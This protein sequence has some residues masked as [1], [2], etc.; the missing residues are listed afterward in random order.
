MEPLPPLPLQG[1][2]KTA[3][4]Q[5]RVLVPVASRQKPQEK[6]GE[7]GAVHT[8]GFST[9]L[10]ESAPLLC[11]WNPFLFPIALFLSFVAAGLAGV[12]VLYISVSWNKNSNDTVVLQFCLKR[13]TLSLSNFILL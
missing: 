12:S 11:F 8:G 6:T 9:T 7:G 4:S 13:T 5:H 3:Y 1:D 10:L 2:T